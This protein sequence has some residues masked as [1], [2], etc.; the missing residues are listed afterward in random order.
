MVHQTS[1]DREE[2]KDSISI[3][4]TEDREE[5][6]DA[7]TEDRKQK[8]GISTAIAEDREEQKDVISTALTGEQKTQY[9]PP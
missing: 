7:I 5:Q 8:E 2:Q 4:I 6:K 9:S 1:P 3:A